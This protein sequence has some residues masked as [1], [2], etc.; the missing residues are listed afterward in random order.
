MQQ[1]AFHPGPS[2][3]VDEEPGFQ[4]DAP[5]L[6]MGVQEVLDFG[7]DVAF[8]NTEAMGQGAV[9][10]PAHLPDEPQVQGAVFAAGPGGYQV[11]LGVFFKGFANDV[12]GVGDFFRALQCLPSGSSPLVMCVLF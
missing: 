12:F 1:H 5:F 7:E 2:A 9:V 4:G 6:F 3:T 11:F 10:F 8:V